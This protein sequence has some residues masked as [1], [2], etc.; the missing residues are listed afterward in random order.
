MK[1]RLE[2]YA[3]RARQWQAESERLGARSRLVCM[4]PMV[5]AK[6]ASPTK[7]DAAARTKILGLIDELSQ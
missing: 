1:E 3:S 7:N 6:A 5:T 2:L 4:G